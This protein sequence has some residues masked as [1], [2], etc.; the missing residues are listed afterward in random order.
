M[1][2][3]EAQDEA[4]RFARYQI[5]AGKG[6]AALQR[7][8][9][10]AGYAA[11]VD[12]YLNRARALLAQY[13]AGGAASPQQTTSLPTTTTTPTNIPAP[14]RVA[15]N[16]PPAAF[17]QGLQNL[18]GVANMLGARTHTSVASIPMPAPP[19]FPKPVVPPAPTSTVDIPLNQPGHPNETTVGPTGTRV[20]QLARRYLG[21]PYQWGG[22][23]PRTGFD[24]SGFAQWLYAQQGVKLPRVAADQFNVGQHVDLKHLQPGDLVFFRDASGIHHEGIAIG[25]GQFIHAPHTGDVVK[26][27]SLSDPYYARQFAGGRRVG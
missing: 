11:G 24:C 15:L 20:V 25:S 21:T 8:A 14:P 13:G 6:A 9:D 22:E 23:S 7:P 17:N 5:H 16:L 19:S 2:A 4:Q 12:Q 10:P 18:Q 26:I 27:S 3:A 1:S